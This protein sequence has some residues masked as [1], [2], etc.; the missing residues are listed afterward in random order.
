MKKIDFRKIHVT[1]IDGT[2]KDLDMTQHTAGE[3]SASQQFANY[4][5]NKTQ[6]IGEL[7][8]ARKLYKAE[9]VEL[10]D[11][12]IETLRKYAAEYFKAFVNEAIINLI[13]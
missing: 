9:E 6:D 12:E 5:Y 11:V 4:I 8:F 13:K 1:Q 10:S 2:I 3:L 7:E